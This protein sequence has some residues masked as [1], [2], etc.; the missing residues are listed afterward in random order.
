MLALLV[1]KRATSIPLPANPTIRFSMNVVDG[2]APENT[3]TRIFE[4]V[5]KALTPDE[6]T[7]SWICDYPDKIFSKILR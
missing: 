3:A 7:K 1:P 5:L 4:K 6:S 2:I